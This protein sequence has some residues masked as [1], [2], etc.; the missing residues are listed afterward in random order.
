[1]RLPTA[2]FF[3]KI[4]FVVSLISESHLIL[5]IERL[6]SVCCTSWLVL[7]RHY[8]RLIYIEKH[9]RNKLFI[10]EKKKD[11]NTYKIC[12]FTNLFLEN[13]FQ[14]WLFTPCLNFRVLKIHSKILNFIKLYMFMLDVLFTARKCLWVSRCV[15]YSSFKVS[16]Q[17]LLEHS[18][19][20]LIII[21][22]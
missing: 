19:F 22:I 7:I 9:E 14:W 3:F 1:M 2:P 8:S 10:C 12:L 16:H 15:Q 20:H 4:I 18:V 13:I 6:I 11:I 5:N 21:I 17:G